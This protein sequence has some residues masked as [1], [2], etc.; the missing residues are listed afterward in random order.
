MPD[1]FDQLAN[2]P[3]VGIP[4][5]TVAPTGDIFDRIAGTQ[6]EPQ[7]KPQSFPKITEENHHKFAAEYITAVERENSVKFT[8]GAKIAAVDQFRIQAGLKPLLGRDAYQ[9]ALKKRNRENPFWSA[10]A[11]LQRAVGSAGSSIVG[12]IN[13]NLGQKLQD[14]L[15][16]VTGEPVGIAGKIGGLIGSGFLAAGAIATGGFGSATFFGAQGFGGTRVDVAQRRAEG[17]EISSTQEFGAAILTAG[18]EALSGLITQRVAAGLGPK[19]TN[20]APGLRNALQTEGGAG[21]RRFLISRL[22][23]MLAAAGLEGAEEAATQFANNII[24]KQIGIDP[25]RGLDLGVVEAGIGGAILS[26]FLGGI[27][28]KIQASKTARTEQH[29][30]AAAA[31][32]RTQSPPQSET[33]DQQIARLHRELFEERKLARTDPLTQVP[34]ILGFGELEQQVYADSDNDGGSTAVIETDLA[35][36]KIA[37]D[38]LGHEVGDRILVAVPEAIREAIRDATDNRP[39]DISAGDVGRI[40]GDEFPVRLRNVDDRVKADIV[41]KRAN[42]I[43]D[44]KLDEIIGDDLP[45][46]ARP[47]IAWGTEIRTANDPRSNQE[48][49][50]AAEQQI[51]SN[52]DQ[53]KLDRG[54]PKDREGLTKFVADFESTKAQRLQDEQD[55]TIYTPDQVIKAIEQQNEPDSELLRDVLGDEEFVLVDLPVSDVTTGFIS[56]T[57][58]DPNKLDRSRKGLIEGT[59]APPITVAGTID[60]GLTTADGA[61]RLLAAQEAGEETISAFVPRSV[62]EAKG[63]VRT[64]QRDVV[65]SQVDPSKTRDSNPIIREQAKD[66]NEKAGL[67]QPLSP[68]YVPV[69]Q[70]RAARIAKAYENMNHDPTNPQV[71]EA[72]EALKRE[73]LAQYEFLIE[74]GVIFEPW[75]QTAGTE[76]PYKTSAEMRADVRRGHLW[77]YTGGEFSSDHPLVEPSGIEVNDQELTYNDLFRAI[78]DYF[79][80]A[81]EG[82]GFG[83]RGE[84]NAWREHMQMYSEPAQRAMTT[85]TRGQSSWVN[86]GPFGAENQANLKETIYAEQK[87]GLLPTWVSDLEGQAPSIVKARAKVADEALR[88]KAGTQEAPLPQGNVRVTGQRPALLPPNR[89]ART[90]PPPKGPTSR[91]TIGELNPGEQQGRFTIPKGIEDFI[92]PISTRLRNISESIF[93]RLMRFE[94]RHRIVREDMQRTVGEFL[95]LKNGVLSKLQQRA[96]DLAVFNEDFTAAKKILQDA[97]SSAEIA[98]EL[99]Q[100]L[101]RTRDILD[102]LFSRAQAVGINV[103]FRENYWPRQVVDHDAFQQRITGEVLGIIEL[104]IARAE[105]RK[106]RPITKDERTEVTNRVIQGYGPRKPGDGN[107]ANFRKRTVGKI[108]SSNLDL[109]DT[110]DRSVMSY[111]N[112]AVSAIEKRRFFGKGAETEEDLFDTIGRFVDDRVEQGE[113]DPASQFEVI[114]LLR[115]RFGPGEMSPGG[116]VRTMRDVGHLTVLANPFSALVQFGDMFLSAYKNGLVRT[117]VSAVRKKTI[118]MEDLGIDRIAAEFSE[119]GK[120]ANLLD[121]ALELSQFKRIDRLGK[122]TLINSTLTK[123]Q[124]AV[125]DLSSGR[126]KR[127]E[128][129]F[130]SIFGEEFEGLVQDLQNHVVTENVRLLMFIE[131]SEVQ[132]ITLSQMP[133]KYLDAPNGRIWYT[134]KTFTITQLDFIRR[135][136]FQEI[137]RGNIAVGFKNLARFYILFGMGNALVDLIKRWLMG[138]KITVDDLPD[139]VLDNS[140]R[141]FGGSK[142]LL[143]MQG[144]DGLA[145]GFLASLLPPTNIIDDVGRDLLQLPDLITGEDTTF[146]SLRNVPVIGKFMYYR[147]GES[148]QEAVNRRDKQRHSKRRA[149]ARKR[150]LKFLKDGDTNSAV[151]T[152]KQW[153]AE[154]AELDPIELKDLGF[155]DKALPLITFK[156]LSESLRRERVKKARKEAGLE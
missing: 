30:L 84:E 110:G 119:P 134:L 79:G 4:S 125:H 60:Q 73:T 98:R 29:L 77:F 48:L 34:N 151:A 155:G 123:A 53:M 103:G 76:Q 16:R 1:I 91:E 147:F 117:V 154:R 51:G 57:Q 89:Q 132:P 120:L 81:K 128:R 100:G 62:A 135:E 32:K 9:E 156:S 149:A 69:D 7:F 121:K 139:V 144:R 68:K 94:L 33:K 137:N 65:Q 3:S 104:A 78:H 131:L 18:T 71:R 107:P 87:A 27:S 88:L 13:A 31:A 42:E 111:I 102:T 72:Y 19:L 67:L 115:S 97:A 59:I 142:F 8:A 55:V 26:P 86:F 153:N 44:R 126:F 118:K 145:R 17:Q 39:G 6:Q 35:N 127:F 133:K 25:E 105:K 82:T 46:Q 114:A 63:L 101:R 56:D 130:A 22:T 106:G 112:R 2:D 50:K 15:E 5:T 140:L 24:V 49:T 113:L 10:Q 109:Y 150:A 122:E 20:L 138:E 74:Q 75:P 45:R 58:I 11:G 36:F 70:E 64:A 146:R 148:G 152:V 95:R 37:N 80:H 12:A 83:P 23:S 90:K 93:T 108:D 136:A 28:G 143:E 54:I 66:Y 21:A 41:M 40:G 52:K 61:H 96:F 141:V 43:F 85:E 99:F 47:F 116:I 129:K 92:T 38:K 124:A 14:D